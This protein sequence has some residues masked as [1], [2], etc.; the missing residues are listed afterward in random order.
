MS[1]DVPRGTRD[2]PNRVPPAVE[3]PK[4]EEMLK[5]WG[6]IIACKDC[7]HSYQAQLQ[8]LQPIVRVC[9]HS[10]PDSQMVMMAGGSVLQMIP[11]VVGDTN[12]CHQ[13]K[14]AV[15]D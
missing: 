10:P 6:R 15:V 12:F 14:N 5:R 7:W 11:R 2:R 9:A 3:P 4:N 8:P 1:D 13:F